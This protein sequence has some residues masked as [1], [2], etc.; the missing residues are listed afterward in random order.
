MLLRQSITISGKLELCEGVSSVNFVKE[1]TFTLKLEG[2][3][4]VSPAE[5][6][7]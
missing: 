3:I 5:W 1:G 7:E 2:Q 4:G 6:K